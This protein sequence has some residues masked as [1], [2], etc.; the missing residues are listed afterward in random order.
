MLIQTDSVY[1]KGRN[2]HIGHFIWKALLLANPKWKAVNRIFTLSK[3][4]LSVFFSIFFLQNKTLLV[5]TYIRNCKNAKV[6]FLRKFVL[7]TNNRAKLSVLFYNE[8]FQFD[9]YTLCTLVPKKSN[10]TT[11][12]Q[13]EAFNICQIL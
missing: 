13:V 9:L 12:S 4:V 10:I 8:Y 1:L 3:F 7:L 6:Y 5:K 2:F 11:N